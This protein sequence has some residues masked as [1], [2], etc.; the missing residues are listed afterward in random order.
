LAP[1]EPKDLRQLCDM[2]LPGFWAQQEGSQLANTLIP[3]DK[4]IYLIYQQ[5]G[6]LMVTT[7][8]FESGNWKEPY[9]ARLKGLKDGET[10]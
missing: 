5:L 7:E 10:K 8:E 1:F 9:L 6:P 2:L 3:T 4:G